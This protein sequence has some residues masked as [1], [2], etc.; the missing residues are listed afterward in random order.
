MRRVTV[1]SLLAVGVLAGCAG[2]PAPPV[3]LPGAPG[4]EPQVVASVPAD[5]SRPVEVEADYLRAMIVHHEQAVEMTALAPERAANSKVRALSDRIGA[6]QGP[7][8]GAMRGWLATHGL[9]EHAGH[10]AHDHA[11][12]PGM[13]TPEQMA[14]LAASRGA[15]FDR[16]FLQLMIA[17]H[18]GAVTMATDL[19][20]RGRDE[21]VHA[22][23]QDVLATQRDEIDTMRRMLAEMG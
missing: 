18:E 8:I 20:A 15:D 3:V 12:M 11:A 22:M 1:A 4:D 10:G 13:A 17:H 16:L 9:D 2:E 23:A 19:L 6:A 14:Q 7:E 5:P 21:Q